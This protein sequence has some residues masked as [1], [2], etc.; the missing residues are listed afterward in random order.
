MRLL[1]PL[2]TILLW[3]LLLAGGLQTA[4]AQSTTITGRV[5][6][7]ETGQGLASANISVVGKVTGTLT[8]NQGNF[9]LNIS[10]PARLRISYVGYATQ[11]VDATP[12]TP[13]DITLTVSDIQANEV[14]VSASRVAETVLQAP[15]TVEKMDAVAIA[16]SGSVSYYQ[17]LQNLKGVDM[18]TSSIGFQI[19]NSR[20]FNSTGNTRM[21]QLIDGMD[22]QAP[23]LNFPVGNIN[24]PS[25]L[26]IQSVEFLPGA[27]SALYGPQ[28]FSGALLI[29]SKDPFMHQGLSVSTKIGTHQTVD[30]GPQLPIYEGSIRYAEAFNDKLAFKIGITYF[31]A[32]D[33]YGN[34]YDLTRNDPGFDQYAGG[35]SGRP[36]F[37]TSG[38]ARNPAYNGLHTLGD[39]PNFNQ[40][41]V[42]NVPA[43]FTAA[44]NALGA[45]FAGLASALGTT[46]N[47]L[48]SSALP[49]QL[50]TRTGY[51]EGNLL[52]YRSKNFR[53][54]PAIHWRAS[55]NL[56][57]IAQYNGGW[58]TSVY[59]G[60]QRYSLRDFSIQQFKLE[61]RGSNYFVRSYYTLENSGNS[62]IA[63]AVGFGIND[64]YSTTSTTWLP[65][66]NIAY[67]GFLTQALT[68]AIP[69]QGFTPNASSPALLLSQNNIPLNVR[70]AAHNAARATADAGRFQPGTQQFS[71][72][73]ES[74]RGRNLSESREGAR[75]AKFD[76]ASAL[77]HVE[78]QYDFKN[79]ID[80]MELQVGGNYRNYMMNTNGTILDDLQEDITFYEYGVYAQLGK[81]FFDDKLRVSGSIRY[82]KNENFDGQINPRVAAQFEVAKNHF[83]RASYQTGFR[84][85]TTQGQYINLD[86]G[87]SRLLGGLPRLT[88]KYQLNTNTYTEASVDAANRLLTSNLAAAG[89]PA[90]G[91]AAWAGAV[92]ASRSA[93]V[94]FEVNPLKPEQVQAYELGYK[95]LIGEKLFIDVA[96]Y[97]NNY[98]DFIS[99]VFV[100]RGANDINNANPSLAASATASLLL[101]PRLSNST[102]E[103]PNRSAAGPNTQAS[104]LFPYTN[105]QDEVQAHG[106]VIG[107]EYGLPSNFYVNGNYNWNKL[108][109]EI[110][111]EIAQIY[112]FNT[113]EHKTN[114]SFGNKRVM[115]NGAFNVTWRWQDTFLW[116][117]SFA[118]GDVPAYNTID[119]QVSYRFPS[120]KT[121]LKVGGQNLL[122]HRYF[123]NYGGPELGAI[124]YVQLTF[125]TAMM[126]N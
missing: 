88:D 5:K 9:K 85:A 57:L 78:G 83:I 61:A 119:A 24:G 75:G 27:S 43:F 79:E 113:P 35:A 38:F 110:R 70:Q 80:F 20:G 2:R 11:E 89:N 16:Q 114:L 32:E 58:G 46:T 112:S 7:G 37:N 51:W 68:G 4:W 19:V 95:G 81:R 42:L 104:V 21:I 115:K 15:V 31:T 106:L 18:A 86:V 87:T 73:L 123:Q 93:L 41:A 111:P 120:I 52:D 74:I 96:Y 67:I 117:S 121:V 22:V 77:L 105:S 50:I 125:D 39:E 14:V 69:V 103:G 54:S 76:D 28:A 45:G 107:L 55:D 8:D 1:Y 60:A 102:S 91:S 84:F 72:A 33:W 122:N 48:I 90:T 17:G 66:Y 25:E 63:D 101:S 40:R 64:T 59:T 47:G 10:G 71:T 6:D 82:D 98:T 118:I 29:T 65:T 34:E 44:G 99:Q 100:R 23:V 30:G 116:E 124:Y 36:N 92:L 56:E 53:I 3:G 13:V 109:T 49:D 26:D 62:Y 12:G 108:I 126:G 94:A 97:Y